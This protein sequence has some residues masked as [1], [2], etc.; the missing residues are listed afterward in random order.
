[1]GVIHLVKELN[2]VQ[3][4]VETLAPRRSYDDEADRTVNACA[5]FAGIF[6]WEFSMRH[7]CRRFVVN[8]RDLAA[9]LDG[10]DSN[11]P[12]I[13]IRFPSPPRV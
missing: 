9:S 8:S 10:G 13:T 4:R 11:V 12:I 3:A 1:M 2:W 5:F 6:N 7:C